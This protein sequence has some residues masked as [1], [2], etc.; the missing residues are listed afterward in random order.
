M[1]LL[2]L[3]IKLIN[4]LWWDQCAR[5]NSEQCQELRDQAWL[6][7]FYYQNYHQHPPS[8]DSY[9]G[10]SPDYFY[11]LQM[12]CSGVLDF[13]CDTNKFESEDENNGV[14][15]GRR[16]WK[17]KPGDK[18]QNCNKNQIMGL[19]WRES[20]EC[21]VGETPDEA[22]NVTLKQEDIEQLYWQKSLPWR[23]GDIW[24]SKYCQGFESEDEECEHQRPANIWLDQ[25]E[26]RYIW[27][28]FS[29]ICRFLKSV[30]SLDKCFSSILFFWRNQ[31][32]QFTKENRT[33]QNSYI[34]YIILKPH[35]SREPWSLNR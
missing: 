12:I 28:I 32:K 16:F 22:D 1:H 5:D 8:E 19:P 18:N 21:E 23:W 30:P 17:T 7:D 3:L 13:K 15:V 29:K 20:E 27:N 6:V 31:A 35:L 25:Q 4:Y 33:N 2:L 24:E 10:Q 26:L 9:I 11:L 14:G 34:R